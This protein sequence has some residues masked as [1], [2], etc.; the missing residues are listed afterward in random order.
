MISHILVTLERILQKHS[1]AGIILTVDLNQLKH[2]V[3]I[4]SLN[5][6]QIAKI[7]TRVRKILT[8]KMYHKNLFA[9]GALGTSDHETVFA[10]PCEFE[11]RKP[12]VVHGTDMLL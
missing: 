2:H 6:N 5:L 10:L 4:S 11:A 12:S 7:S 3:L 8:N 9:I 1:E